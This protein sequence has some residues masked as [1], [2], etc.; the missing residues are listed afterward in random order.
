MPTKAYPVL[1]IAQKEGLT[2]REIMIQIS[3]AVPDIGKYNKIGF[4]YDYDHVDL[5]ISGKGVEKEIIRLVGID[6]CE[7][8]V[9]GTFLGYNEHIDLLKSDIPD[10]QLESARMERIRNRV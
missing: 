2:W 3:D 9:A 5:K 8:A 10:Y 6:V 7:P 4:G 1:T